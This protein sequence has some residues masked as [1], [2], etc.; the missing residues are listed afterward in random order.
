M[1]SNQF[2][3]LTTIAAKVSGKVRDKLTRDAFVGFAREMTRVLGN[4]F[5]RLVHRGFIELIPPPGGVCLKVGGKMIV[6]EI[7][8]EKTLEPFNGWSNLVGIPP[9]NVL[10]AFMVEGV[11]DGDL[12]RDG[13][14]TLSVYSPASESDSG[15]NITVNGYYV[16][17]GWKVPGGARIFAV[18]NGYKWRALVT[19]SCLVLV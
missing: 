19:D 15:I 11:L 10:A 2:T 14:A 4:P 13:T 8:K 16:K 9:Y 5:A 7:V 18:W 12:T 6:K 17:T 3:T 1:L